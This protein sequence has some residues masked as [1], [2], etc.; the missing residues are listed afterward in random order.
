[1]IPHSTA[2]PS[3]AAVATGYATTMG[4]SLYLPVVVL[5]LGFVATLFFIKAKRA[6]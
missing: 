2:G 4:D 6:R 3:P 1:M 5:V